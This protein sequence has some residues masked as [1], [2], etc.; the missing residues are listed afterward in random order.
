MEREQVGD[1]GISHNYCVTTITSVPTIRSP[2]GDVLL[3]PEAYCAVAASTSPDHYLSSV[4]HIPKVTIPAIERKTEVESILL[5]SG[6]MGIVLLLILARI[7]NT[8]NLAF[9][10]ACGKN[11]SVA[12]TLLSNAAVGYRK[13]VA[14]D[15]KPAVAY[16]RSSKAAAC[17]FC[18][19]L[20]T[21][22]RR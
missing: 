19:T 6:V 10:I 16:R 3:P 15:E 21:W 18:W 17:I 2:E 12:L 22:R 5:C 9:G 7:C 14:G 4:K 8:L 13:T 20:K 1:A 11:G